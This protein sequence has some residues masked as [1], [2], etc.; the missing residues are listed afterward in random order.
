MLDAAVK[1]TCTVC[2]GA[3]PAVLRPVR[4]RELLGHFVP[5]SV[6]P[7]HEW[8]GLAEDQ[9]FL[10]ATRERQP[11]GDARHLPHSTPLNR[12]ETPPMRR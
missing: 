1:P 8:M 2:T 3:A 6:S 9:K 7:F 12:K 5:L 10:T 11:K 4:D